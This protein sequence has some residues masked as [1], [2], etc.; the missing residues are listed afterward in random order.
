ML[1]F[2]EF[3]IGGVLRML[4]LTF[5]WRSQEHAKQGVHVIRPAIKWLLSSGCRSGILVSGE[6]CRSCSG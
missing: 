1:I 2:A 4:R 3:C 5:R 6:T